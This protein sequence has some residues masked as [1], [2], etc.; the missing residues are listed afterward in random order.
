MSIELDDK[1]LK[2]FAEELAKGIKTEKDLGD[3]TSQLVKL[4]VETALSA[5][6]D[7]HLGYEKHD[8]SWQRHRKQ[9]QRQLFQ[10]YQGRSRRGGCGYAP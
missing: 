8:P 5:E 10:A 9:P 1:K 7:E 6:L 4:T 3:L 2:A